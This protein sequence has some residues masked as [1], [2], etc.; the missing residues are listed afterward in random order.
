MMATEG[1]FY[2]IDF[3]PFS[4]IVQLPRLHVISI[5]APHG[6]S[7]FSHFHRY[8]V[9]AISIHAPRGGSDVPGWPPSSSLSYFNP[10]SPWGERLNGRFLDDDFIKFQSTLPA[11]GATMS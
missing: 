4:F 10:R 11:G 1:S 6:G 8:V 9:H 7:D 2:K 5:H 3:W